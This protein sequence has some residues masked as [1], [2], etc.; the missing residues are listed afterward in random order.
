[1]AQL[2]VEGEEEEVANVGEDSKQD[3]QDGYFPQ[4][5]GLLGSLCQVSAQHGLGYHSTSHTK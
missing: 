1:M 2:L 3:F 5:S 4:V